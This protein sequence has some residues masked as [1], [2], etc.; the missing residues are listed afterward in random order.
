MRQNTRAAANA[1]T[2][3]YHTKG[4]AYRSHPLRP[5]DSGH[6]LEAEVDKTTTQL[7]SL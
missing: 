7:P 4:T 1:A 3:A 5:V 2:V 6:W